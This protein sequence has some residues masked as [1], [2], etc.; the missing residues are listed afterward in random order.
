[1][2]LSLEALAALIRTGGAVRGVFHYDQREEA[3]GQ[4]RPDPPI[5]LL[6]EEAKHTHGVWTV[7]AHATQ[8]E[9]ARALGPDCGPDEEGAYHFFPLRLLER[10]VATPREIPPVDQK[11]YFSPLATDEEPPALWLGGMQASA[12]VW[13]PQFPWTWDNGGE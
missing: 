6:L 11:G 1:M 10:L 2:A 12:L 8:L 5:A 9:F 13:F 3:R 4:T 7:Q